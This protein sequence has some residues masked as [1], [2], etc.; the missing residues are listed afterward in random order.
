MT[1]QEA[2]SS[3]D[4]VIHTK[5]RELESIQR[6]CHQLIQEA[7]K[8]EGRENA[9]SLASKQNTHLLRLLEQEEAKRT[10]L[11]DDKGSLEG[12]LKVVRDALIKT[13]TEGAETEAT[14]KEKMKR[15]RQKAHTA[16]VE[17]EQQKTAAMELR[18]GL[19]EL[20]RVSR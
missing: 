16:T 3:R 17:A 14:L 13:T 9:M 6:E 7:Q 20:K 12:Q 8:A 15:T 11:A 18:A 2:L 4:K 10:V 5:D 1:L 19:E